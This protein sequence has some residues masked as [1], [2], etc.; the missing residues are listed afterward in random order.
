M[1]PTV[2]LIEDDMDQADLFRFCLSE[3][4]LSVVVRHV[5][6]GVEALAYLRR[7]GKYANALLNPRPKLVLLDLRMPKMDGIDVLKQ[8][9][10]DP[11]MANIPT[12]VFSSSHAQTD[13]RRAYENGANAFVVKPI[14]FEQ[15]MQF[16]RD[17]V[18]F[19]T[20]WN[21]LPSDEG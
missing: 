3:F 7:Q 4:G 5:P 17:V 13:V 11:A 1:K 21:L 14:D 18:C 12:V 9:K 8:I 10:A 20:Q 15:V 16:F 2:L 6:D 19:W